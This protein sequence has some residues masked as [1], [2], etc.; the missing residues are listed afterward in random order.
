MYA[1][2]IHQCYLESVHSVSFLSL[3]SLSTLFCL[4]GKVCVCEMYGALDS[5]QLCGGNSWWVRLLDKSHV[6]LAC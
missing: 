4:F 1:V 6:A 5:Q 2:Y 3:F